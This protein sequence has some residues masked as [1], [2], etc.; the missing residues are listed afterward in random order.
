MGPR[1]LGEN[2]SLL[3]TSDEDP[4]KSEV[5]NLVPLSPPVETGL[6]FI[7]MPTFPFREEFDETD[8]DGEI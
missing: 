7:V 8:N 3:I 4:P 2:R 5:S 1:P 6:F